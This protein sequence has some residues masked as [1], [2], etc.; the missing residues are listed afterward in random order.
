MQP[1]SKKHDVTIVC[2]TIAQWIEAYEM[3]HLAGTRHGGRGARKKRKAMAR[4]KSPKPAAEP[5][6][7]KQNSRQIVLTL[8]ASNGEIERIEELGVAGKRRAFTEAEFAKL[9]GDDGLEDVCEALEAAYMAGIQDGF[10]DND[11]VL[12][13]ASAEEEVTRHPFGEEVLRTGIRRIIFRRAVRRRLE[14]AA[15]PGAQNGGHASR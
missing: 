14:S 4:K 3:G 10:D 15:E 6:S 13:T 7:K 5:K 11:D 8:N 2:W 1:S 9:A 12:V